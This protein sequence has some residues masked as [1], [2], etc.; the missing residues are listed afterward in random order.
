[1]LSLIYSLKS[2]LLKICAS[3]EDPLDPTL[4]QRNLYSVS[5]RASNTWLLQGDIFP[6]YYPYSM[7]DIPSGSEL[8]LHF[9][10]VFRVS[11][12]AQI[13][14]Q[15][16]SKDG[17]A[18]LGDEF[19]DGGLANQQKILQGGAGFSCCQVS[20]CYCQFQSNF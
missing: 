15:E 10:Q 18:D 9:F 4:T 20:R 1:M 7:G 5:V 11:R 16:F 6:A 19:T 2:L 12:A 14:V 13:F 3:D 17:S 8:Y